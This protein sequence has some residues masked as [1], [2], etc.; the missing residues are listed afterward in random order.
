M[1]GTKMLWVEGVDDEKVIQNLCGNRSDV[2]MTSLGGVQEILQEFH[3]LIKTSNE[4]G[5][6]V[7]IVV[8]ADD[9][10]QARWQSLY[11]RFTQAGYLD[12]PRD[13]DPQGTIFDPPVESILPR[14]GV[15][16]MPD[17]QSPGTL[18][19]FLSF[20]VPEPGWLLNHAKTSVNSIPTTEQ[21]FSDNDESKAIMH[22][23]L[24]WQKEPG[25]PYGTAI[26]AGFLDSKVPQA[27]ALVS[28]LDRLFGEPK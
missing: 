3:A 12:I 18:E 7:G 28:W 11:D 5:S 14:A 22:T 27:K 24:A 13:Q 10:P 4:E 6:V 23:W 8:D 19:D 2:S 9:D 25:R 21:L 16:I 17:N 15:W 26:Q 20:L 1:P